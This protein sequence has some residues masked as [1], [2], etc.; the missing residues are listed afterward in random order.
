MSVWLPWR[1]VPGEEIF[2]LEESLFLRRNLSEFLPGSLDSG[3]SNEIV[4][5]GGCSRED[6]S[7]EFR[8][9]ARHSGR[10]KRSDRDHLYFF[11][12]SK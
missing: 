5:F 9:V 4:L 11:G 12:F 3:V 7:S 8:G 2:H 1:R 6:V 10:I